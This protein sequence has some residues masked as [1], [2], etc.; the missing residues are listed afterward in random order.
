MKIK[1]KNMRRK[2][3]LLLSILASLTVYADTYNSMWKKVSE[4]QSKDLP[5]TQLEWLNRIAE[6]AAAA[7]DWGHL[8]RATLQRASTQITISPDS[9]DVEIARIE[10]LENAARQ[11]ELKAVYQNVLGKVYE[12]RANEDTALINKSR[13]W[14]DK[15]LS[16]PDMLAKA[17]ATDFEP[18]FL[19][20]LDSRIFY[21]DLLHVLGME[22]GDYRLLNKYYSAHDNRPA[23]CITALRSL[24]NNGKKDVS[25]FKK[26]KYVQS[27]D[28]LIRLY[29]DL[30]E[31]GEVAIERYNCMKQA[32]DISAEEKY[33]YINIA[34]SQWGEWPRM[35]YLRN[36]QNELTR[37]EFTINIGDK[38]ALPNEVR[39]LRV[40]TIRNINE[41]TIHVYRLNVN[42][43]QQLN[44]NTA[45]GYAE[46]QKHIVPGEVQSV[47]KRYIGQPVWK[48]NTDSIFIE[49]LPVGVYLVEAT[50]GNLD[51]QPQ[52]EILYVSDIYV[53]NE[54]LPEKKKLFVVVNA[55]TGK[56]ISGAHLRVYTANRPSDSKDSR[57][58][59]TVL[60][61]DKNGQATYNGSENAPRWVYAWTDDDKA[62]TIF[63][64]N[65]SYYSI[66]QKKT[67]REIKVMTDRSLYRPG[68]T[69]HV[70]AVAYTVDHR[71]LTAQPLAG[72]KVTLTLYDTNYEKVAEQEVA[73]DEYGSATA[74]FSLPQDGLTGSYRINV[75]ADNAQNAYAFIRVEEYKRPTY[76]VS[77]NDYKEAYQAGDTIELTGTAKTFAGVPVQ[78]ARVSYKA[79]RKT[80]YFIAYYGFMGRGYTSENGTLAADTVQTD[81]QGLFHIRVPMLFPQDADPSYPLYYRVEV[82]AQVTDQAGE[83]HEATTS[84]PLSNRKSI[85]LCDLP[86]KIERDSLKQFTIT[87]QNLTGTKIDG[88]VRYHI[89][90][91]EWLTAQSGTPV[92]ISKKWTSGTHTLEAVCE[93]DTLKQEI[94]IFSMGDKHP[95][96]TTHD[97]YYLSDTCFPNDGSPVYLQVGTSDKDVTVYYT[98]FSGDKILEHGHHTLSNEVHTQKFSYKPQYG[99]GLTIT[100]AWVLRGH[101]YKHTAQITRPIPDTH[102]QLTWKTFRDRLT[103]GTTEDWTLQIRQPDGKP[104]KTQ[105]LA[106]M[107]DKSLDQIARHNWNFGYSFVNSLPYTQ[108]YGGTNATIGLYGFQ[109]FKSLS[110]ATLKFSH[111]DESILD[112][113]AYDNHFLYQT[114]GGLRKPTIVYSRSA[115]NAITNQKQ[116]AFIT[117]TA[118]DSNI[119]PESSE[120]KEKSTETVE[121]ATTLP[122]DQAVTAIR[123]NLNETAFWMPTL[124][125]DKTGQ[126]SLH[127]TLPE[128]ITTWH[129]M[130]LAHDKEMHYGTISADAVAS[131]TVMVQPNMPRFLRQNDKATVSTRIFNTSEKQVSGTARL[132]IID[133]ETEKVALSLSRPFTVKAQQTETVTF[134]IDAKA[135]QGYS[136]DTYLYIARVTAEGRGYSDGEQHWL[137]LLPDQEPVISTVPITQHNAGTTTVD[138]A[139][140]FPEGSSQRR[141]T[142]EYTNHPAWLMIQALPSVASP[143]EKNSISLATAIYA[144]TIGQQLLTSSPR[145][146]QTIQ[147][148]QMEKGAETSLASQLSKNNELKTMV[149]N[150]TPWVADATRETQQRQQ[151]ATFLNSSTLAAR[152]NT[153]ISDLQKLQLSDGSFPWWPGMSGSVYMTATVAETLAR[154]NKMTGAL[155]TLLQSVQNRAVSYL[156]K[157]IADEVTRLKK[158]E[159]EGAKNLQPSETACHILYT[160]TLSGHKPNNDINYLV[161]L[162]EKMPA[163]LTIY[164]KA[165]AA[166]ILNHYGK[167]QRA[168]EFVESIR[169]YSVY[170]EDLGRYFDTK[171][172]LYSWR[173]YRIPTEVAAIEALQQLTPSDTTTVDEMR[174][175]LLQEKRTQAW[176][177]PINTVNAVYAFLVDDTHASDKGSIDMSRLGSG[178]NSTIA[179]DGQTVKLPA[180][181][182]GLGYVKTQISNTSA[183]ELTIKKTSDG[184]S[185]GAVYAQ[186]FQ[187]SSTITSTAAGISVKREVLN[188]H[189]G[190]VITSKQAALKVGDKIR[191]RITL[192]ADR[193]YDFVQVEDKRA[194]C[195]EPVGQLS[196]YHWGYYCTPHDNATSYY[197]DRMAKGTHVVETDYYIDR[198]GQYESGSCTAQCAYSPEF[199]GREGA[200]SYNVTK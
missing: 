76:Q 151:I 104:A 141:L 72:E 188:P 100:C 169:Q 45:T 199:S 49:G 172:A 176:D 57:Y 75:K 156:D 200:H 150:E 105:L 138:L 27:L 79:I 19:E 54:S 120:L 25:T 18:A 192:T 95:A 13:R 28:S 55:T 152:L 175:W 144:N 110:V 153:Q 114:T 14:F 197:F 161:S 128:S 121:E 107:Y 94:I 148:W 58:P 115:A 1:K 187:P 61:T 108:W 40:N 71:H 31:C 196:G 149:L 91:G 111:I 181:T 183:K 11:P 155:P 39:L 198:D 164:G 74:D 194:A 124:T 77:F 173:D 97:W 137:P 154:L 177:T 64:A 78:N 96:T 35:N 116:V 119:A 29:G 125:S 48:E 112:G 90:G 191:I 185:W 38:M 101:L 147:Q 193:D 179:V 6:K 41:L 135:L 162:L 59:T 3:V 88:T 129:F 178:D 63:S 67:T 21:D 26:S 7:G 5:K 68:Q 80:S 127:F 130:A 87:R 66:E 16:N 70:K 143:S 89:D 142:L 20:G 160:F 17:K 136:N 4:A 180:G 36:E 73:T 186:F 122:A 50:T 182:A 170:R 62:A 131:K 159:K 24:Q 195:L 60:T 9:A 184:T 2:I 165:N 46:I 82:N 8:L 102:L 84:M 44:P 93:G 33:N 145:I 158:A 139:G 30:R 117:G 65:G 109:A 37:P 34:L 126:V 118:T 98:V 113:F 22:A 103:P 83:S 10:Q 42:G 47:T 23:A 189:T 51:I 163:G 32:D 43:D 134:P 133:P 174:R 167:T 53:M 123:D 99:D 140:L 132:E 166:I 157:E 12:I 92:V 15:S 168:K 86:A 81:D 106:A 52:R 171:K 146:A 85:L 56:P 69:T 190:E